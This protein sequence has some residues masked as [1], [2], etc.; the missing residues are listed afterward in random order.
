LRRDQREAVPCG[1]DKMNIK[2]RKRLSH[3]L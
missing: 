1:P 3:Y 2:L